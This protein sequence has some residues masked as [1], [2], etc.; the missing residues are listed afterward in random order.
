MAENLINLHLAEGITLH[1]LNLPRLGLRRQI[2]TPLGH[3]LL[4]RHPN[5]S[6]TPLQ[7]TLTRM[8][9]QHLLRLEEKGQRQRRAT[10]T[11]WPKLLIRPS[12]RRLTTQPATGANQKDL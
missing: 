2:P 9:P 12:R 8:D 7:E 5:E 3:V 11:R 1:I 4:T 10:S 6:Q